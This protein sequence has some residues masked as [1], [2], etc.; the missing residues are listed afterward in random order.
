MSNIVPA[1]LPTSYK[2]LEE[3][4]ALL[5]NISSI[6]RVQ[7][8]IVDGRFATPASWPYTAPT[9][10]RMMLERRKM[11]P[12]LDRFTYE[13]DLMCFDVERAVEAWLAF[14]ATRL[15]F[16]AESIADVPQF[17]A[18]MRKR[19]GGLDLICFGLA[20][21][22]TSDLALIELCLSEISYV[23]FMGIARIGRQGQPF[24]ERVLEKVRI[25]HARHPEMTLQV[26]GGISLTRAKELTKLGVSNLVVGSTILRARDPAAEVAKL[27]TVQT[28]YGV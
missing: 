8:D 21:N 5:E 7:I 13:I 14:G 28:S 24:D 16:H 19:H 2:D 23:Q 9:E 12:R 4:L 22:T 18:Y 26:D 6:R 3:K 15:T 1:V 27:E 25:F 17:L 10:F 20:L 11:L